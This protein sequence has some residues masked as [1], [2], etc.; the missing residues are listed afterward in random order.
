MVSFIAVVL[1]ELTI[2]FTRK[3]TTATIS[4]HATPSATTISTMVNPT[5]GGLRPSALPFLIGLFGLML[6]GMP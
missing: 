4:R 6:M 3:A 1:V 2:P 5:F